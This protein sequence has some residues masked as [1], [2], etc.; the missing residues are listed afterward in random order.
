MDGVIEDG[1]GKAGVVGIERVE[2]REGL[3]RDLD[4]AVGVFEVDAGEGE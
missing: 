3:E 2:G 1:A 4:G